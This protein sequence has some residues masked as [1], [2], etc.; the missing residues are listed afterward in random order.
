M[1][2]R[3]NDPQKQA[4]DPPENTGGGAMSLDSPDAPE[5][6]SAEA[7]DPPENTKTKQP[8]E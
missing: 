2:D 5:E 1:S 4:I 7:I 8:S 6:N 3:E